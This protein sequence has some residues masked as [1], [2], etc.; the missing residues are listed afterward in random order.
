MTYLGML[1]LLSSL[2]R[3]RMMMAIK[4]QKIDLYI[5]I[6]ARVKKC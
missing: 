1:M 4:V 2:N 6:A 3:M 5:E